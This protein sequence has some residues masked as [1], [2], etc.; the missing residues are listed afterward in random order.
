[1]TGTANLGEA[2]V[3]ARAVLENRIREAGATIAAPELPS[4]RGDTAQL[5]LVF[6]NLISNAIKY[7]KPDVAPEIQIHA[8]QNGSEWVIS[9]RDNGIGFLPKYSEL[10]FGLFKRLHAGEYPGTG[11][12]L[13]ICK[14]IV[15]RYGGR[16]W[17]EG[18]LEIG[19]TLHFALPAAVNIAMV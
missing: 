8:E 12:G 6:Q 16:M 11:L 4:V 9:V 14:R 18:E 15:E 1:V 7:R 10:I 13:A 3:E 5:A 17:A 2:L 19:A